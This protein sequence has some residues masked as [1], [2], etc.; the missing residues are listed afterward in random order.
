MLHFI[1]L[2]YSMGS[3]KYNDTNT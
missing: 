3:N 1:Y 2:G